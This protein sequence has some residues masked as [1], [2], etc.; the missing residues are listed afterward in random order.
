MS[1]SDKFIAIILK[2]AGQFTIE[3]FDITFKKF[4]I[5]SSPK[6]YIYC[7]D[8]KRDE[9]ETKEFKN[10][11]FNQLGHYWSRYSNRDTM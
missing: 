2:V 11:L 10:R 9:T 7:K 1:K 3:E 4:N 6:I 8:I 5:T